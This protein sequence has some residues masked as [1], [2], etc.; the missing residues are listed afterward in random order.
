MQTGDAVRVVT[1]KWG[2]RPHWE[3]HALFLGSD[4]HGDWLGFPAGS[5][6]ARPGM[7]IVTSN[8]QVG[9]VP[10]PTLPGGNAWLATFHAAGGS[11]RTYVDMTT[12]PVWDGATVHAVDL[13]LDVIETL[14]GEVFVDDQDEFDRHRLQH[15]YPDDV[16]ALAVATRDTIVAAMRHR[17]PPFDGSSQ[18]WLARV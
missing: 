11:V 7:E 9:L 8:D 13:D 1:T 2:G 5:R 3:F 4:E 17:T 12:V 15:A 6:M 18:P 14:D 16:V 10:A